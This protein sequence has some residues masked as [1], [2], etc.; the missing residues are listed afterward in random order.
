MSA[1]AKRLRRLEEKFGGADGEPPLLLFIYPAGQEL[2]LDR[3]ACKQVLRES[4]FLPTG[5]LGII[6]FRTIPEGLTARETERF[7][8]ENAAEICGFSA[9]PG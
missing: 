9:C 2:A 3:E 8:R 1:I 7:L 5:R 4:G 6:D